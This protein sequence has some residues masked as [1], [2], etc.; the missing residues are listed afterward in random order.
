[1][2]WITPLWATF[3]SIMNG[4]GVNIAVPVNRYTCQELQRILRR[5]GIKTWAGQVVGDQII[6]SVAKRDEQRTWDELGK[7]GL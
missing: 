2:D 3:G 5:R 1:M 4:G 6:F 7:L